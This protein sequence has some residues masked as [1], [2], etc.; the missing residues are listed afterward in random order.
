MRSR[1]R[2]NTIDAAQA[3]TMAGEAAAL[4]GG[5]GNTGQGA[6]LAVSVAPGAPEAAVTAVV[7]LTAKT[8]GQFLLSGHS[9][10]TLSAGVTTAELGMQFSTD[11]GATWTEHLSSLMPGPIAAGLAAV[12]NVATAI[13]AEIVGPFPIG[14]N[15]QF[16]MVASCAGGGGAGYTTT[17]PAP[18]LG[19]LVV[20][21]LT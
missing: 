8:S 7:A 17:A 16:R 2:E 6:Q 14:S 9:S 15:L 5:G 10:G 13:P 11:G 21:E 18:P 1:V 19:R 4:I 12:T 3:M 20:Q